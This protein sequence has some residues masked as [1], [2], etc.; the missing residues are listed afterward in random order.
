[1]LSETLRLSTE[2]GGDSRGTNDKFGHQYE[3]FKGHRH[4]P[5]NTQLMQV[6]GIHRQIPA[7]G[8]FADHVLCV[9]IVG[10]AQTISELWL[11]STDDAT[12]LITHERLMVVSRVQP[13]LRHNHTIAAT[14]IERF[15]DHI[16]VTR[17]RSA[18]SGWSMPSHIN[19]VAPLR[20]EWPSWMP[21]F[22]SD[23]PCTNST[24][25]AS[26]VAEVATGIEK[27]VDALARMVGM[28]KGLVIK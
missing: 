25:G 6:H 15:A 13:L 23:Q 1:M 12:Q 10:Q 18:S 20:P 9:A 2:Y 19:L 28:P 8:K 21:S 5:L 3:A 27:L 7:I 22:A 26:D 16:T 17:Y 24:M 4:S 11:L 14:I